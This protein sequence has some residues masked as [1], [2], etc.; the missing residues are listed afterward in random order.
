MRVSSA[1]A[2]AATPSATPPAFARFAGRCFP[3]RFLSG[4]GGPAFARFG[5]NGFVSFARLGALATTAAT[6]A[7]TATATSPAGAL[8][9]CLGV[10]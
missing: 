7:P 8:A 4:F 10:V 6:T 5:W 2:T 3:G 1:A 9:F